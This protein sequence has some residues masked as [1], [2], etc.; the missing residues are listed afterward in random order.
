MAGYTLTESQISDI[1]TTTLKNFDKPRYNQL[2]QP[3]QE[4][5]AYPKVFQEERV[6][7]SDG[8]A[9]QRDVMLSLSDNARSVGL[10]AKD[11]INIESIN[12]TIS[13]PWRHQTTGWALERREILINS[14]ASRIVNLIE[15]RRA[16]AMIGWAALYENMFWSKPADSTDAV[17]MFGVLYWLV[18]NASAGFN[19]G[20]PSGFTA[21]AGGLDASSYSA[22]KNYTFNYAAVSKQDLI[23]KLRTAYAL[24][25]WK[26]PVDI[27]DFRRGSG[28]NYGFYMNLATRISIETLGEAQNENLGKDIAS[29]DGQMM[30]RRHPLVHVPQLNSLTTSNPIYG[31]NW[32]F[33]SVEALSGDFMRES[34]PYWLPEQHNSQVVYMDSTLNTLCTDR[35]RQILGAMADPANGV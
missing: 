31:L 34:P 1:T 25:D 13:V 35:R 11:N 14:G 4:Y 26:S 12:Q 32:S 27:P 20:N 17:T 28:Q 8:Y 30:F 24:C 7:E 9:I 10:H 19:G 3:I 29:F 5:I 33:F 21:G 18:Y 15:Q 6:S 22:W 16:D 23:T 2:A